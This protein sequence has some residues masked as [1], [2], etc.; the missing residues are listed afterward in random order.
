MTSTATTATKLS[1][2]KTG[3]LIIFDQQRH[4]QFLYNEQLVIQFLNQ[5][6]S[7][8]IKSGYIYEALQDGVLLCRLINM[9]KPGTIKHIGQK[10][11]SFVKMDNIT[12]FIKGAKQ[13]G[14]NE[15]QLFETSDLFD[16]KDIHAVI[17]TVLILEQV[18]NKNDQKLENVLESLNIKDVITSKDNNKD[19]NDNSTQINTYNSDVTLISN[20]SDI[21]LKTH[22]QKSTFTK[23]T[24]SPL[25]HNKYNHSNN[26][27]QDETV[28]NQPSV[29]STNITTPEKE[30]W[31]GSSF[32][33]SITMSRSS[34]QTSY[35]TLSSISSM[36]SSVPNTPITTTSSRD[37]MD[38]LSKMNHPSVNQKSSSSSQCSTLSRHHSRN[39]N[40][41][42]KQSNLDASSNVHRRSSTNDKLPEKL[43]IT[44]RDGSSSTQYQIGNCIGKGQFGSVYRALDLGTGEIVAVKRIKIEDG[45]LHQEISKE[46]DLLKNLSHLNV[47]CYLG[48]I[49]SKHHM[50]IILEFAENGS[51][52]STLKSFGA[53]PEKLVCSFCVKILNGLEYLH[54]N[55]V[56]HCDLKAANILTTK[57][58]D[59]KL[60]D[61]GVSLNLKIKTDETENVAGTPNWM[62]PEVIELKGAS[63]K[64][65]IWSLGCT[66]IELVSG[67]PPYS[68]LVAMSAMFRIVEDEYPPLPKNISEE[69]KSFLL[70]CFQKNP[71]NRPTATQLKS[72]IWL[73][74]NKKHMKRN[75]TYT[76]NLAAYANHPH[77]KSSNLSSLSISSSNYTIVPT[78]NRRQSRSSNNN[79]NNDDN[80][81]PLSPISMNDNESNRTPSSPRHSHHHNTYS[82][83][84]SNHH[85]KKEKLSSPLFPDFGKDGDY[86]TH[87]FIETSLGKSIEC[88]VC[89]DIVLSQVTLCQAC[90]LICHDQ[91]KKL[92]FSCPPKV[93]EQQPSYDWVFSAKIYN[94]NSQSNNNRSSYSPSNYSLSSN[95]KNYTIEDHPHAESIRRYSE[96]LGLT[97]QE[98]KALCNN[99]ALLSH[100]LALET[101]GGRNR[102]VSKRRSHHYHSSSKPSKDCVIN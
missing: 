12:S 32:S 100:T 102:D 39:N 85:K 15:T 91:C 10:D 19:D 9:I 3:D 43:L 14:L 72:H 79:N 97:P 38:N 52:M 71:D 83:S 22:Q 73:R 101:V 84:N 24:K 90:G 40:D 61:F 42:L 18:Y 31:N 33:S 70:C 47:I 56:V 23:P 93:K 78:K 86:I 45:E 92:A 26:K 8:D 17:N 50:N 13:I 1:R 98:Q 67:K 35:S 27:S 21:S 65:D 82:S 48:V 5:S 80:I 30:D 69:M 77:L 76:N 6:L 2:S 59:V 41:Q 4:E 51:L 20:H 11:L 49:R 29:L 62:A 25:R 66:L 94:R 46:I 64:S 63:T 88:K 96:T 68:N 57:T 36:N 89:G 16:G 7:T 74:N 28:K 53:F 37:H 87:T 75:K 44:N 54:D 99:P 95:S 58:G 81:S 34:S 60:T 55:D